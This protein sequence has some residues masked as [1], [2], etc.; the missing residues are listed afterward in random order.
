VT[1]RDKTARLVLD[2]LGARLGR[3][4]TAGDAGFGDPNGYAATLGL[5]YDATA[6]AA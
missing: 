4:V 6:D 5:L 3:T 1:P 2:V